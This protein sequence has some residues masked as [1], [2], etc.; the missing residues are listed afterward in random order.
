MMTKQPVSAPRRRWLSFSLR[1]LFV[2]VTIGCVW[3]AVVTTRARNQAAAVAKIQDLKGILHF[4]YQHDSRGNHAPD[5]EPGAPQWLRRA[6]G[7][8]YFRRVVTVDLNFGGGDKAADDDLAVFR[9]LPDVTTLELNNNPRVTD[10]GLAHLAGLSK[11]RVMYL[12]RSSVKGPGIRH[13]PRN[14]EFL[15]LTYAPLE[16]E[17]LVAIPNMT[18]LKTLRLGFTKITDEGLVNLA[19]LSELEDLELRNTEVTDAG[20]EHLKS[21]KNLKSLSLAHT[22]VT[23]D[24]VARLQRTL[25]NCHIWPEPNWLD[26]KPRV[27]ELW[28]DDYHPSTEEIVAKIKELDGST[29]VDVDKTRAGQPIISLMLHNSSISDESLIRLLAEM[30]ELEQLNLRRVLVGDRVSQELQQLSKLTFLSL[31]DSRITDQGLKDVARIHSLK[32]LSLC[33]TKISDAGLMYLT[34]L[35]NL[36]EVF[37]HECKLSDEGFARFR[38]AMPKC[39]ISR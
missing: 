32:E 11:L 24:G 38:Q 7:E 10:A 1:G 34:N 6:L 16:D 29:D 2:V 12:Y 33:S 28:P 14:I 3:L 20:L 23:G 39:S 25:P 22:K 18:K 36:E 37:V 8:D 9:S 5:A 21:L 31:D 19:E 30:P 17:G 15:M 26:A 27:I 35:A 13:L 4:D